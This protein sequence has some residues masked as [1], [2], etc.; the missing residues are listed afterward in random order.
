MILE[1][2]HIESLQ[3]EV[4]N[5]AIEWWEEYGE[6]YLTVDFRLKMKSLRGKNKKEYKLSG[7]LFNEL[8]HAVAGKDTTFVRKDFF[9]ESNLGLIFRFSVSSVKTLKIYI[10]ELMY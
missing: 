2:Y 4:D 6:N 8:D 9:K 1:K 5:N 3:I 10:S 7:I